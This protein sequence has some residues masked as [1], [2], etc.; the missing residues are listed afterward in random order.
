MVI[1]LKGVLQEIPAKTLDNDGR[2]GIRI[3]FMMLNGSRKS[4]TF[5]QTFQR[6]IKKPNWVSISAPSTC[7][8]TFKLICCAIQEVSSPEREEQTY[9][10]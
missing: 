6:Q 1:C 8:I 9:Y 2:Y 3:T 10:G 5:G 4:G 7:E